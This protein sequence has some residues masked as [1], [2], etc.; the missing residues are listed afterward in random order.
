MGVIFMTRCLSR[1][2]CILILLLIP[3]LQSMA[4]PV[5]R[6]PA[7]MALR[8]A[9]VAPVSALFRTPFVPVQIHA[10]DAPEQLAV[11]ESAIFSA[12]VNIRDLTL[13]AEATW[14]FGDGTV[15]RG[16]AVEHAFDEAGIYHVTFRMANDRS[17]EVRTVVVEVVGDDSADPAQH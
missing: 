14:S 7:L 10:I 12:R 13:P 5:Q 2:G 3:F 8:E 9:R 4:Q 6:E 16:L 15:R 11:G 1:T 17:S